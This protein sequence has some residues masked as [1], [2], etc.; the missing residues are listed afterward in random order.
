MLVR[1][2]IAAKLLGVCVKTLYRWEASGKLLPAL[3]TLG[4]HRSYESL[5]LL[6]LRGV[7]V[8]EG[9]RSSEGDVSDVKTERVVG[10]VRV[11]SAKQKDDL[12]RQYHQVEAYAIEHKWELDAI[13][14]DITSGL[15]DKR[16]GL[17]RLIH[18]CSTGHIDRAIITYDDRL[19]RFSTYLLKW[20]LARWNVQVER[21]QPVNSTLGP[22]QQLFDDLL[23][24]MT[25]FT[26]KFHRLRR[27]RG[28]SS[29]TS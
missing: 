19:A 25:S 21:I 14:K 10:Y 20:L 13:Y 5:D 4:G 1:V 15:N 11:S 27:G 17:K 24:L 2:G 9:K 8:E 7:T 22:E 29:P 26:G 23:A 18:A 16:S 12:E 6:K 3:R 28:R